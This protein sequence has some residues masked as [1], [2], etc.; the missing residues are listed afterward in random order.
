RESFEETLR[1][2]SYERLLPREVA[3]LFHH[4]RKLGNAAAHEVKGSHADAPT[5]IKVARQIGVWFHRTYGKQPNFNP[6][7]FVP[8][9]DPVDA[10]ASPQADIE[11][12]LQQK[13]EAESS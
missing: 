4:I 8:P 2:L 9:P 1:R 12:L 11:T 3:D 6:G 10:T 5:T 13:A 7:A